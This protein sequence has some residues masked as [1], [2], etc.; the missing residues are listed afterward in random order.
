MSLDPTTTTLAEARDWLRARVYDGA[1]CPCCTQRTQVYERVLNSGMAASLIAFA[2]VTLQLK[3]QDGWLKVSEDFKHVPELQSI[4]L[5]SREYNKLAY[6][7]LL[8][9]FGKNPDPDP[10]TSHT[11]K[12]RVTELGFQFVRNEATVQDRVFVFAKNSKI[13]A[14]PD[15]IIKQVN[16]VQALDTDFDYTAMMAGWP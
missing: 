16:V 14:P 6:W 9:G 15:V 1:D 12:W 5:K 8:E 2:R 4:I 13:K 3:P 10:K 11:G 7:G